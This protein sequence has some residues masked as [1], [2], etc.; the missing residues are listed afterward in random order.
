ME[1]IKISEITKQRSRILL[2]TEESFVLY[3]GEI[4]LLKL[5]EGMELR[6]DTYDNIMKGILPKRCKMRAMNLLKERSYTSYNLKKKL[7]DGGYPENVVDDTLAY[8]TSFGYVNDLSFAKA[9]IEQQEKAH[10]RAEI[11]NKLLTKG[12]SKKLTDEAYY[13]LGLEREEYS[14]ESSA[15]LETELI[16]KTLKKRGFS[17]LETYEEKQKALAYFYRRGFDIDKVRRIMEDYNT[18]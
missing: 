2:D 17:G 10:T 15:E 8:V 13:E 7:S 11:T 3:K 9:Y 14:E 1:I 5:K 12:I 4:R 16:K 6:Q 18:D